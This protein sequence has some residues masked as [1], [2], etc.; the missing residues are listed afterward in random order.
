MLQPAYGQ[1]EPSSAVANADCALSPIPMLKMEPPPTASS[2]DLTPLMP[3][4]HRSLS[5]DN[6]VNHLHHPTV[7]MPA[8]NVIGLSSP[9][10]GSAAATLDES[11]T[12]S[13][14]S[15]E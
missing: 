3:A 14:A 11:S 4:A 6:G 12:S 5:A 2:P 8:V 9:R 13:T 1:T 15:R 7:E 10:G